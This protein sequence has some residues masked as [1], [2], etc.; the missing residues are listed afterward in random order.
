MIQEWGERERERGRERWSEGEM[1]REGGRRLP[2]HNST[3][4]PLPWGGREMERWVHGRGK[5]EDSP[6]SNISKG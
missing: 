3:F 6:L 5:Q 1:V 4:Y 2:P